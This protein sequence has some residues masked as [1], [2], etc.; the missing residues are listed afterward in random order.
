MCHHLPS[1]QSANLST[2]SRCFCTGIKIVL[3]QC[4]S[5]WRWIRMGESLE[6]LWINVDFLQAVADRSLGKPHNFDL[7]TVL[8]SQWPMVTELG[9]IWFW[10]NVWTMWLLCMFML[11]SMRLSFPTC[12]V[13]S[14]FIISGEIMGSKNFKTARFENGDD[15]ITFS[16]IVT[17]RF[18][19]TIQVPTLVEILN[20]YQNKAQNGSTV[21]RIPHHASVIQADVHKIN[22]AF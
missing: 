17:I 22:E 14:C 7:I 4:N 1:C 8:R 15:C 16:F 21:L 9:L 19:M 10:Q 2:V 6:P 11:L 12:I 3:I 5:F 18:A 20:Y 13:I